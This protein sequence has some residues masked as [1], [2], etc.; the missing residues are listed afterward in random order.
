MQAMNSQRMLNVTTG[1][2]AKSTEKLSS[3]YRINR[4]ADDA[5]G[6]AISE[7]MRKQIRGLDRASTNAQDGVS[8]V[9]TAEGALGEVQDMLQRMNELAVQSANGTNSKTDRDAIQAEIDQLSTEIDR[10][11]ETTKFNETYLLKGD[12]NQTR[13]VSYSFNNNY[14][15]VAATANMY[16]DGASNI[17]IGGNDVNGVAYD[18][19][20][21][22]TFKEGAKQDDQNAIAKALRDQGVTVT[23]T[24]QY[25]DPTN[26]EADGTVTNGYTLTLNG[27]AAQK[28]KVVTLDPGTNRTGNADAQD[29]L[30]TKSENANIAKF[31]IQDVNGNDIAYINVGGANMESADKTEKVKTQTAILTAESVTAAKNTNEVSQYFDKDG[32]KLSENMLNKY[33]SLVSGGTAQANGLASPATSVKDDPLTLSAA[34]SDMENDAILTK[35]KDGNWTDE[36]G[37]PVNLEDYGVTA[38]L[39]KAV[40]GATIDF[41]AGTAPTADVTYDHAHGGKVYNVDASQYTGIDNVTLT[42]E[43]K[44]FDA[45]NKEIDSETYTIDKTKSDA[46]TSGWSLKYTSASGTQDDNMKNDGVSVSVGASATSAAA[47]TTATSLVYFAGKVNVTSKVGTENK[48]TAVSFSKTASADTI[49]A[50]ADKTLTL[51]SDGNWYDEIDEAEDGTITGTGHKVD[52]SS[53]LDE[54]SVNSLT[55]TAGSTISFTSGK[56]YSVD[57]K[58]LADTE[59]ADLTTLSAAIATTK[60]GLEALT[61]EGGALEGKLASAKEVTAEDL[62]SWGVSTSDKFTES[63][64]KIA[65]TASKWEVLDDENQLQ[66]TTTGLYSVAGSTK[67]TATDAEKMMAKF[68]VTVNEGK[69]PELKTTTDEDGNE[70]TSATIKFGDNKWYANGEAVGGIEATEDEQNAELKSTYGVEIVE[71]LSPDTG[72]KISITAGTKPSATVSYNTDTEANDLIKVRADAAKVYDAVG[73]DTLLDVRSISAKRDIKGDLSLKLHVGADATS[74]NQIQVN[75]ADMSAKGLGVNGMKVDGE[76]DTNAR[77][78]IETIKE[79]L[80]KVSDQRASLGA[81]QNRLEHTINNLDNVVE[82]TTS[83]ESRI[84]DTDMADERQSMLAQANQSTQGVLSILG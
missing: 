1:Q 59:I 74:N 20:T 67:D 43:K 29:G 34:A 76:D 42:Y 13:Q 35:G 60:G 82:N 22:I 32:N 68:G 24:S 65:Y 8:A 2:Q 71:G 47:V 18:D 3:G 78:A 54:A 75:I 28:Y 15:T 37:N 51:A 84:R 14:E 12:R 81:A 41:T 63:D 31:A 16:A 57:T 23:Y 72:D 70:T 40:A 39:S 33:Y 7:K 6:L 77:N 62:A 66:A 49:A 58:E 48:T 61:G 56:W 53:L 73:N 50:V 44:L 19:K 30:D 4:A 26:G 80:Q 38:D 79:A 45:D 21:G 83:A 5:A 69:M 55:N 64:T 27:D 52:M 11:S 46:V 10:V 17:H 36:E 25:A 9:Q